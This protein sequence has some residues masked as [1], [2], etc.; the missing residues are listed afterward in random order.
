MSRLIKVTQSKYTVV[1]DN[2]IRDKDLDYKSFGMLV[3]LLS[4]V[5]KN[6]WHFTEMGLVAL[7]NTEGRSSVRSTLKKLEILGYL[8]RVRSRG[9]DGLLGKNDYFISTERMT[10]EGWLSAIFEQKTEDE[11]IIEGLTRPLC[12]NQTMD[13]NQPLFGFPTLDKPTLVKKTQYEIRSKE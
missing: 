5:E 10:E 3:T 9:M 1:P 4:L 12:E 7:K 13:K 6:K 11:E 2:I 8:R